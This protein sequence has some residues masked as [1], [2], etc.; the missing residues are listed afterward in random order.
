MSVAYQ[1]YPFSAAAS[2]SLSL[3]AISTL[4]LGVLV[5]PTTLVLLLLHHVLIVLLVVLGIGLLI[6][7]LGL[8]RLLLLNLTHL[9]LLVAWLRLGC[10]WLNPKLLIFSRD[11]TLVTLSLG[12][13][14]YRLPLWKVRLR[15]HGSVWI[16]GRRILLGR[17]CSSCLISLWA[18]IHSVTCSVG[19]FAEICARFVLLVFNHLLDA[20]FSVFT[21]YHIFS[22]YLDNPS[23]RS[24][25]CRILLW[26]K[27]FSVSCS[28]NLL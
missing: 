4:T 9:L 17:L 19:V 16:H 21:I 2:L 15:L 18:L 8:P 5:L 23:A 3:L 22:A 10:V 24:V 11:L 27:D 25:S 26:H 1:T 20:L 28:T 13:L 6:V 12:I 14:S 7:L